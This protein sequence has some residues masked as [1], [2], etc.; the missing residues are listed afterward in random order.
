MIVCMCL[1]SVVAIHIDCVI[2]LHCRYI[3]C[4]L[5]A[6]LCFCDYIF[7]DKGEAVRKYFCHHQQQG[8]YFVSFCST[9]DFYSHAVS[10]TQVREHSFNLLFPWNK[11]Y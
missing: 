3:L 1:K 11:F 5:L 7:Q 4:V 8:L 2:G 9:P 6:L 10:I